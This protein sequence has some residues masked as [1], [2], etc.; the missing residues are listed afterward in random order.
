MDVRSFTG[1]VVMRSQLGNTDDMFLAET[2]SPLPNS[3]N[4]VL[5]G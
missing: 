5:A 2:M 3:M 4:A 1:L